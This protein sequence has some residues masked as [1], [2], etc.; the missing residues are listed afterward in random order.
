MG[1]APQFFASAGA[2]SPKLLELAGPSAE[3]L[4]CGSAPFDPDSDE[5]RVRSFVAAYEKRFGSPPDFLAAN[6]YDAIQILAGLIREGADTG[7]KLKA[8][9]YAVKDYPG[10]GGST[11]FDSYGD[12]DKPI[13]LVQ[14]QNGAFRPLS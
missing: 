4:V 10:I 1:F 14:V 6:S 7:E 3:G 13:I 5:P 8:G 2:I 12:V 9:L 11:T